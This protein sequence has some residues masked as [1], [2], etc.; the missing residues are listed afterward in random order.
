MADNSE[1]M[2]ILNKLIAQ[3]QVGVC[4]REEA[5]L[6]NRAKKKSIASTAQSLVSSGL[7]NTTMGAGSGQKWEEEVGMPARLSL[8]RQR[9]TGL[10]SA[11]AAKAGYLQR[12]ESEDRRY[13]AEKERNA[14]EKERT[15][16]A[17]KASAFS[18][19][20]RAHTA[21]LGGG[22]GGGS[23]GFM[24][25]KSKDAG[26]WDNNDD[27]TNTVY[28]PGGGS[29]G[30]S[31]SGRRAHPRSGGTGQR[32]VETVDWSTGKPVRTLHSFGYT[33]KPGEQWGY[34]QA[35]LNSGRTRQSGEFNIPELNYKIPTK[36][37]MLSSIGKKWMNQ[38]SY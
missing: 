33:P 31:D 19:L 4:G 22:G 35:G 5:G 25:S 16:A 9:K 10:S 17:S 3:Y 38:P 27:A 1:I 34:R 36:M 14:V 6:L 30:G 21:R 37:E 18:S 29:Q 8:E 32:Q 26:F 28:A 7:A 12:T 20:V 23:T 2:S 13:A 15:D 24:G 11:L